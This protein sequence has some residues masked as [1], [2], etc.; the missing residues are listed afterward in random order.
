MS[1]FI[2]I[3]QRWREQ[4]VTIF[5]NRRYVQAFEIYPDGSGSVWAEGMLHPLSFGC[6]DGPTI[7]KK[8]ITPN[9]GKP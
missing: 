9:P 5:V 6:E 8:I 7:Q 3:P 4:P 2:E 1:D